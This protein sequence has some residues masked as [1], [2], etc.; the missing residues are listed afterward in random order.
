MYAGVTASSM[1]TVK[2]FFVRHNL[3]PKLRSSYLEPKLKSI[4]VFS[5]KDGS[6]KAPHIDITFGK[7]RRGTRLGDEEHELS[8][9]TETSV[10][11]DDLYK[12]NASEVLTLDLH[13]EDSSKLAHSEG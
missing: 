4:N 5:N 7:W 6:G 1:P 11:R 10:N 9:T 13:R 8:V 2:Q 12:S 3:L